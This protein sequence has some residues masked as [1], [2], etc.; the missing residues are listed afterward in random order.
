MP[1]QI[2]Q[3]PEEIVAGFSRCQNYP[4]DRAGVLLFAQALKRASANTGI[5]MTEVAEACARVSRWC[6][7]DDDLFNVAGDLLGQRRAAEEARRQGPRTCLHQLCDGSGW[8][9]SWA[10]WTL[11]GTESTE[12]A[13]WTKKEWITREVFERLEAQGVTSQPLNAQSIHHGLY[14]CKCHPAR[15]DEIDKRGKYA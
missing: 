7:T 11:M 12:A 1:E 2:E 9:E 5:S 14:R 15:P 3:L 8:R 6:P 4:K 13:K 10:L